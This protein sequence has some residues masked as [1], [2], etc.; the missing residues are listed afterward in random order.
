MNDSVFASILFFN[1]IQLDNDVPAAGF[2]NK[3]WW[4]FEISAAP[5][6]H[7]LVDGCQSNMIGVSG[8]MLDDGGLGSWHTNSIEALQKTTCDRWIE[9]KYPERCAIFN[10]DKWL[11]VSKRFSRKPMSFC[12]DKYEWPNKKNAY[13]WVMI[14][15]GE[16]QKLC[17]SV[18]KRLCT[19]DEWTFACEG[20]EATPFPYGYTR[21]SQECNLDNPWKRYS[22]KI[23]SQRGSQECS[24][25]LK[26]LWKGRR[27]GIS[28][29]CASSF[30]VEDMNGSVD[31][32]TS[33]VR[34]SQ[35]PY[36]SVLKGGYWSTVR[37]RC[38]PATRNHGP[39]HTFYQQGFRCC[40]DIKNF[41]Q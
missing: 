1:A 24:Q 25:E 20:E 9:R 33:T 21:N 16:S 27:S 3:I 35:Y 37:T 12:I 5:V 19:E 10:R 6:Q 4:S 8:M 28:P 23:L 32:W 29:Q 17:E 41:K 13:P 31:E 40:A 2:I 11:Q 26:R 15:W 18:G 36:P 22:Q 7:D 38:R 34:K 30:G 39:G 14:T